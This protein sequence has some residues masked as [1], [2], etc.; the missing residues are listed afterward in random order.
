MS[1]KMFDRYKVIDV[2]THI[3]EPADVWTARVSSK[4]ASSRSSKR[5]A[6]NPCSSASK[7]ACAP[8]MRY[9]DAYAMR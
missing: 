3:T 4:W 8:T 7:T 9:R 2:D 1:Q 6:A 5:S